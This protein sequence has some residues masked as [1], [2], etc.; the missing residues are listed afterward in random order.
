LL[1][2]L[3]SFKPCPRGIGRSWG[4]GASSC[5]ARVEVAMDDALLVCRFEGLGDLTSDGQGFIDRKAASRECGWRHER[6][7]TNRVDECQ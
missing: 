2:P 7:V 4:N 5:P 1:M 3:I 6:A